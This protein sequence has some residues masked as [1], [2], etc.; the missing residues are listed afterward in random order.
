ME[1][2]FHR[3]DL[4]FLTNPEHERY[5][6][7]DITVYKV[8]KADIPIVHRVLETHDFEGKE[9]G[10]VT[11]ITCLS[12][13]PI[14]FPC[15]LSIF[16]LAHSYVFFYI[17]RSGSSVLGIGRQLM[18][19]K[20]DN[21]DADDLILY[22]GLKWLERRH[23]IGKVR[24]WVVRRLVPELISIDGEQIPPISGIH[25]DNHGEL[26]RVIVFFFHERKCE[27]TEKR[28]LYRTIIRIS[29]IYYWEG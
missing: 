8:P 18:L 1:P 5:H 16:L 2:G 12:C 24:G 15:R 28:L 23:I 7:G 3:G 22:Q 25:H 6:T 9:D 27:W 14:T 29:N 11:S 13:F 4:L 21:N 26:S 19:T 10:Y 17:F 20:G